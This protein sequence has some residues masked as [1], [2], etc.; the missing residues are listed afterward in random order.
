MKHLSSVGAFLAP[1]FVAL[2]TH[3]ASAGVIQHAGTTAPASEDAYLTEAG[4]QPWLLTDEVGPNPTFEGP[5]DGIAWQIAGAGSGQSGYSYNRPVTLA[6]RNAGNV[7]GWSLS[8]TLR[9]PTAGDNASFAVLVGYLDGNRIWYMDFGTQADGDPFVELQHDATT[10]STYALEG[11]GNSG[12]HNYELLYDPVAGTADLFV[13][14]VERISNFGGWNIG[15]TPQ[16]VF[17]DGGDD[18]GTGN[19]ALVRWATPGSLIPEPGSAAV[20]LIGTLAL[21]KRR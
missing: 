6:D 1:V 7:N 15:I 12:Y 19:Y 18:A 10:V 21:L 3:A 9:V 16:V 8:A 20:L 13:D 2:A 17:G 4:V 11:A 14:G 5:V